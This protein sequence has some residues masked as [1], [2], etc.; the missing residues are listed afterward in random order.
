MAGPRPYLRRHWWRAAARWCAPAPHA[1]ALARRLGGWSIALAGLAILGLAVRAPAQAFEALEA[2]NVLASIC[3]A[4]GAPVLDQNNGDAPTSARHASCWCC[5]PHTALPPSAPA[6]LVGRIPAA[7]SAA[8]WRIDAP[9]PTAPQ[10]PA[11]TGPPSKL[12]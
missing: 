3:S 1:R 2:G 9:T 6:T 12:V 5:T 7:R 8:V 10:K 4:S 11:S